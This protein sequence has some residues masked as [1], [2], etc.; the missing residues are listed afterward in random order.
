MCSG[1]GVNKIFLVAEV[2]HGQ[3]DGAVD[4]D[5]AIGHTNAGTHSQEPIGADFLSNGEICGSAA[6]IRCCA[7]KVIVDVHGTEIALK[8]EDPMA[9]LKVVTTGAAAG[10]TARAQQLM[11][12]CRDRRNATQSKITG[13]A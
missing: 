13:R 7:G 3:A 10:E 4:Q 9:S 6:G 1:K 8:T 2:S 11:A 5:R 12:V